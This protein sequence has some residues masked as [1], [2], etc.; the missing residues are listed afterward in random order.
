[1]QR[2]PDESDDGKGTRHEAGSEHQRAQQEG[3]DAGHEALT[4]RERPVVGRDVRRTEGDQRGSLCSGGSGIPQGGAGF[5]EYTVG[6]KR[7]MV[8][9]APMPGRAEG[10]VVVPTTPGQEL[11][12]AT[13]C[14]PFTDADQG[15]WITM[16]TTTITGPGGGHRTGCVMPVTMV[17]PETIG[18]AAATTTTVS[19]DVL[20]TSDPAMV[21]T[22][23]S[24]KVHTSP[25][26]RAFPSRATLS[27]PD[28]AA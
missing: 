19:A 9:D 3:V 2:S 15:S 13:T 24:A 23:K 8:L 11:A 25:S 27:R 14:S 20:L 1:M 4:E 10:S 28:P 16:M 7:L 18:V 6:M 22:P 21:V 12:V 17:R 26:T 5:P